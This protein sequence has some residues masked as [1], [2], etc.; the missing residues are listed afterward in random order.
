MFLLPSFGSI[1]SVLTR[2]ILAFDDEI[3]VAL[4]LSF[5]AA[6]ADYYFT[7][8]AK[9]IKPYLVARALRAL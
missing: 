4:A 8:A 2:R 1:I 9:S 5:P 6:A 3:V 7:N